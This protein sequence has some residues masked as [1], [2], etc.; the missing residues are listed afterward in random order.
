[1]VGR[2][3]EEKAKEPL[4]LGSTYAS[5]ITC[6]DDVDHAVRSTVGGQEDAPIINVA[7]GGGE[8]NESGIDEACYEMLIETRYVYGMLFVF[9]GN[10]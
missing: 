6:A 1:M 7:L 9:T 2:A 10:N 3:R 8:G 5:Q 4:C